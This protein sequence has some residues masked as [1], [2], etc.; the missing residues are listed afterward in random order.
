MKTFGEPNP[1]YRCDVCGAEVAVLRE[2]EGEID[3]ICCH[4]EMRRREAPAAA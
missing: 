4:Q 3:L 2:E 1:V